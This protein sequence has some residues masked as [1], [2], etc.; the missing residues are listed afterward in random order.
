MP[1]T[2]APVDANQPT[3]QNL[4][5]SVC[6]FNATYSTLQRYYT[7]LNTPAIAVNVD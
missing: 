4:Q 3:D 5:R 7:G 6:A 2:P 1:Q